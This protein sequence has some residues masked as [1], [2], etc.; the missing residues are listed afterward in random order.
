MLAQA[1]RRI[2][3]A[4]YDV[5][6][7]DLPE[8]DLTNREQVLAAMTALEP[9]LI[10]NC[11]A[12]TNVDGC[13]TEEEA[14]TRVNGDGPGYLAEAAKALGA[15]LLHVS[16]DYVFDGR[17]MEPYTEDDPVSP[18]SAY[19]RSKLAGERA[20]LE[21]GLEE[22]FILRT[23]WLYGPGGKN[24]VETI[25]RLA[26]ER[27]ELRIVADQVGTPTYT[28]DLA[29]GVF[30]LLK[31]VTNDFKGGDELQVTS[32]ESGQK[33]SLVTRHPSPPYGIYHFSNAGSCSWYDFAEAIVEELKQ[34]GEEIACQ[35][36]LPIR[37]EEYPLPAARP[38]FSVFSKNKYMQAT[39]AAIPE[40]RESLKKYISNRQ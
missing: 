13:E 38:A 11:A 29:E 12:F 19:G 7:Y 39:G 22:Y 3:P 23:S 24:F 37:T 33:S 25:V 32:K 27:E 14:A 28:E 20:I 36:I 26:M 30:N 4:E 9:E 6:G 2:A 40:W 35:R 1:V 8:F 5:F 16:T 10:V 34:S 21:S 17:K 31:T 18:Q 15:A